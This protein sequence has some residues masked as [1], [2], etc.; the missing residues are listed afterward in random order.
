MKHLPY[1][2]IIIICEYSYNESV[3]AITLIN[4]H[5]SEIC[6]YKTFLEYVIYRDHPVVFNLIDNYCLKCN[7]SC[8]ILVD[9]KYIFCK[10]IV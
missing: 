10:H 4:K 9:E 1:E 7:L 6:N 3:F 5:W 8:A 2:L